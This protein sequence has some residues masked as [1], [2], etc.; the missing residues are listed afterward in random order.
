V[1]YQKKYYVAL[2]RYCPSYV[3]GEQVNVG[4]LYFFPDENKADFIFPSKLE[5]LKDLFIDVDI[6]SIRSFLTYIERSAKNISF[7]KGIFPETP[8]QTIDKYFGSAMY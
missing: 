5:R 6:R 7:E 1:N 4:I 8:Q 2:L 3:L